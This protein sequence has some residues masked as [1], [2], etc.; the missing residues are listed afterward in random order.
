[1]SSQP[2]DSRSGYAKSTAFCKVSKKTHPA[3]PATPASQPNARKRK[4]VIYNEDV[5]LVY[6]EEDE[7]AAAAAQSVLAEDDEP[8]LKKARRNKDEEKRLRRFRASAPR[9]YL[10][11]LE[12]VRSQ[13]MFLIDRERKPDEDDT[14]EVE[15]FDLAGTTGNI[16]QVTVSKVPSCTCPDNEKGNQCKHIVYV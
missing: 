10:E 8:Q 5:G 9:T 6:D 3:T 13:R 12:R 14:G 15:V 16:Y 4:A 2:Y 1:M 11:R 7:V